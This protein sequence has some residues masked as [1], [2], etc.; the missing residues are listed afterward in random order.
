M[1][2]GWGGEPFRHNTTAGAPG[3]W[4][5][6]RGHGH[7]QRCPSAL[8]AA[9]DLAAFRRETEEARAA[10]RGKRLD[11]TVHSHGHHPE[12][13]LDIRWIYQHMIEEYARHNGH[14][15][16]IREQIDGVTGD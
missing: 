15:D 16:I 5:T 11:E 13:V 14:A 12:R 9:A 7:R 6:R 8:A 2:P 3:Q 1:S 4:G 10:V